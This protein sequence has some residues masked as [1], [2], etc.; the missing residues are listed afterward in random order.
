[1]CKKDNMEP[2]SKRWITV[3]IEL[4]NNETFKMIILLRVSFS[5]WHQSGKNSFQPVYNS[6]MQFS[7]LLTCVPNELIECAPSVED[8]YDE[9]PFRRQ[10]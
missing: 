1:M 9:H 10:G 3:C 6:V 2:G 8:K 5:K 4:L 7:C